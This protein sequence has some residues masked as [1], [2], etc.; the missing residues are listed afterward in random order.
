MQTIAVI[1]TIDSL[2]RAREISRR[3][4]E[5]RLAA[6][7]QISTIESVFN[8]NGDIQSETEYR[9]LIKTTDARYADVEKAILDLHSYELPAIV[10]VDFSQAYGP[11]AEWVDENS[12]G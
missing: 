7:A 12:A 8:W 9:I 10:A 4:V 3:L 11:Y 5:R 1:T 2:E 6:C